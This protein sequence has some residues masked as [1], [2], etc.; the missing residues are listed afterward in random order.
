M[1]ARAAIFALSFLAGGAAAQEISVTPGLWAWQLNANVGP[2]PFNED[3]SRCVSE[4]EA[5]MSVA[6]L[7]AGLDGECDV[8]RLEETADG[9]AFAL[10]C[11]GAVPGSVA[12]LFQTDGETASIDADGVI[13][14]NGV[15]APLTATATA[16]RSGA[17]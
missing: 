17:C 6:D 5:T 9:I 12:G 2:T 7:T 1:I 13:E 3:G 8:T 15:E 10:T 11:G 14:L 16:N 4:D